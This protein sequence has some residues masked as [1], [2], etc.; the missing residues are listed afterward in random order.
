MANKTVV[1]N[2]AYTRSGVGIRERHNERKNECYSNADIQLERVPFNVHFKKCEGTY[3]EEFDKLLA[4]KVISTR[5]QKENAKIIDEMIFDVNTS[6]FEQNGGYDF[7]K[8]FYQEA[9]NLAVKEVGDERYILSAVMHADEVNVGLSADLGKDVYHYHLHV[10]YV[11]VVKKEIYF[12]KRSKEKA[13]Q[14]KDTI[15]QVSHSKKWW[16]RKDENGVWVNSYSLLQDRFYE[17]MKEA[18]FKDFERGERGSTV[19]HLS[20][21]EFKLK[22]DTE[23]AEHLGQTIEDKTAKTAELNEKIKKKEVKLKSLDEK[24]DDRVKGVGIMFGEFQSMAKPT[25]FGDK[26]TLSKRNWG[27]VLNA[28]EQGI[29]AKSRISDLKYKLERAENARDIY[30]SRWEALYEKTKWFCKALEMFPQR[31]NDFIRDLIHQLRTP[32]QARQ[33]PLRAKDRGHGL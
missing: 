15:N 2:A 26:V 10:I 9:Y 32:Q 6:Y 14:L 22:K 4:D 7:A 3:I 28:A 24:I 13:G 8:Q 17:C 25:T 18:G 19:E 12:S 5:G 1:R 33:T 21:L 27:T 31:V 30:K 16:K 29:V 11:P 23:H 20:D